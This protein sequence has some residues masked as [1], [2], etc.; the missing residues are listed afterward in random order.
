MGY[1]NN[2]EEVEFGGQW[3]DEDEP[4]STSI[5]IQ[6]NIY[7]YMY[8][9]IHVHTRHV[10]PSSPNMVKGY[11]VHMPV[12]VYTYDHCLTSCRCMLCTYMYQ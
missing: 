7:M 2:K 11:A 5:I 10:I 9:H 1:D 12:Q 6:V 8:L 4:V 3:V